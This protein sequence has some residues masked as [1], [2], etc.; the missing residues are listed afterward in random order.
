MCT[1]TLFLYYDVYSQAFH[2]ERKHILEKGCLLVAPEMAPMSNQ[3]YKDPFQ[4]ISF[5]KYY[6]VVK[7]MI[8][9]VLFPVLF[10]ALLLLFYYR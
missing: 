5:S 9:M 8:F 6:C 4:N 1:L 7:C 3:P 2:M 10:S